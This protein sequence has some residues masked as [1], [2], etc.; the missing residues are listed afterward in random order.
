MSYVLVV[1]MEKSRACFG[2][3]EIQ[4]SLVCVSTRSAAAIYSAVPIDVEG[5]Q[6][7]L[8]GTKN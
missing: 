5:L 4:M 8:I 3:A 7:K 1:Q 6:I 2:D